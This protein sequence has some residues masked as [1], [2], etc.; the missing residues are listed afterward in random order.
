M[1]GVEKRQTRQRILHWRLRSGFA[2]GGPVVGHRFEIQ[3]TEEAY[4]ADAIV[5]AQSLGS[6]AGKPSSTSPSPTTP[7]RRLCSRRFVHPGPAP[8]RASRVSAQGTRD[9]MALSGLASFTAE[10]L[11][12]VEHEQSEIDC[13]ARPSITKP[14][15]NV[16]GQMAVAEV[17]M[18]R[19]RDTPLPENRL[20]RGLPG[21]LPQHGLPVHLHL[22]RLAPSQAL[23]RSLGSRP[24]RGPPRLAR[25]QRLQGK[26]LYRNFDNS[27]IQLE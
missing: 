19:V 5:L 12:V 25:V 26:I 1:S 6:G 22:R 21:P 4:R 7:T 13:L 10:N 23:W 24:G 16:E 3:K 27:L 2:I 20:R 18:N 11:G 17:V 9:T 8:P 14:A 15:R